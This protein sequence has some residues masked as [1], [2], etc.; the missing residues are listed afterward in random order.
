MIVVASNAAASFVT[1]RAFVLPTISR[2]V[3]L[4]KILLAHLRQPG[5]HARP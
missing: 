4:R 5:W 1:G 2:P 3:I